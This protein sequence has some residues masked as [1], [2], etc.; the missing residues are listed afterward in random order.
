MRRKKV[1]I[2]EDNEINR[3]ILENLL[4]EE[5]DV[6]KAENGQVGLEILAKHYR[7]LS[8]VLLD[9]YMPVCNGFEFLERIQNDA[10]LN[11]VPVIVTTGSDKPNDEAKCLDLG[12]SD[13]VTKPYNPKVV[14]GRVRSIIKL[15]ESVA[16][17]SE[18]E[19][20]DLCGGYTMQAFYHHAQNLI[21][22]GEYDDYTLSVADIVDF[23]LINSAYGEK[24]GDRV[25]ARLGDFFKKNKPDGIFARQADKFFFFY[26]T[27]NSRTPEE[28]NELIE[29]AAKVT[30]VPNVVV[31]YAIYKNVDITQP[32]SSLCDRVL[33]AITEVKKNQNQLIGYYDDSLRAKR[34]KNQ[35]MEADFE[36]AIANEE[37]VIWYQPKIDIESE[38]IIAA[39]ALVRWFDRDGNMVSP[40]EFIPLFEQDG[41]IHK[42]DAYVFKK[43]CQFQK[44]RIA[45]GKRVVPVSVNLSRSSVYHKDTIDN[46]KNMVDSSEI[47]MDLVPIELTESAAT[48]GKRILELAE[49]L[50]DVGFSLHMDDF[51]SGYSSLSSLGTIPF[52]VLKIDKSLIDQIGT[53]RGDIVLKYTILIAQKLG[54][55]VVAE[56]VEDEK[57]VAFLRDAGCDMIQGYYYSPP[58]KQSVFEEMLDK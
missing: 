20:D 35:R 21:N 53:E 58:K 41:L 27:V 44:N 38:K 22:T 42:L 28:L 54:M 51:G 31:K 55:K 12:A 40:G 17:L 39:E 56:G 29:N 33:M 9:V 15:K 36:D 14:L 8:V 49:D 11:S 1:L 50:I 24:K 48:E 10:L 43:V 5:Y 19:F 34:L 32:V 13:F 6:M 45:E 46:Y 26:P 2:V 23:K 47:P 3:D 7:E 52:D 37:F 18:V 30:G 25:V 16:T 57:Q 4:Q